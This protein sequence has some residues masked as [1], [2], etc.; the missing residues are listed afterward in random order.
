MSHTIPLS[1]QTCELGSILIL[2][3]GR[4]CHSKPCTWETSMLALICGP[5]SSFNFSVINSA[6]VYLSVWYKVKIELS[7]NAYV[8]WGRDLAQLSED[9]HADRGVHCVIC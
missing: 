7:V 2:W 4:Q 5:S 8:V 9:T 3:P 1:G 6:T